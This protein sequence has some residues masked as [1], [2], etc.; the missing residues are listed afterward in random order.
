MKLG[1]TGRFPEGKIHRTDEGELRMA[2]SARQG[3]VILNFGTPI[4]WIGLTPEL[5]ELL[6]EHLREC[7]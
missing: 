6:A 1:Q 3:K 4:A 5:A 2:V 7:A